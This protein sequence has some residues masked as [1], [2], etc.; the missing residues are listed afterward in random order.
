MCP[1]EE[2]VEPPDVPTVDPTTVTLKADILA[3]IQDQIDYLNDDYMKFWNNFFTDGHVP[4]GLYEIIK[5]KNNQLITEL[6]NIYTTI[7]DN[8][9][10]PA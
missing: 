10:D 8:L 1:L 6:T 5:K 9:T 4:P 3:A 7:S 2:Y